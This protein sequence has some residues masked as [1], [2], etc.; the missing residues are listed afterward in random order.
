MR[1]GCIQKVSLK[2]YNPDVKESIKWTEEEV[3]T[4]PKA[5]AHSNQ[6]RE[7]KLLELSLTQ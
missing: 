4:L 2:T 3:E 1:T 5:L 7:K 6:V